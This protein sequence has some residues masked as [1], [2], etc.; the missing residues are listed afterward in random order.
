MALVDIAGLIGPAL[1]WQI[2]QGEYDKRAAMPNP[3]MD[4]FITIQEIADRVFRELTRS[5]RGHVDEFL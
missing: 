4:S 2:V 1:A 3:R 5:K